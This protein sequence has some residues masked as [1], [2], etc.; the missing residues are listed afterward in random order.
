[1]QVDL[2]ARKSDDREAG[3]SLAAKSETPPPTHELVPLVA[4]AWTPTAR[5]ASESVRQNSPS[6]HDP[7]CASGAHLLRTGRCL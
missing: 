5:R 3:G 6:S 2:A 4:T 7:T 1:M